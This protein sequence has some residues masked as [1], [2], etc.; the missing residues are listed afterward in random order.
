MAEAKSV[1]DEFL[2]EFYELWVK[3]E[4]RLF[5]SVVDEQDRGRS[6]GF[7]SEWQFVSDDRKVTL[8]I[9][10]EMLPTDQRRRLN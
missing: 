9:E 6:K 10:V 4:D 8:R 7:G 5:Q 2:D 3:Y 1:P